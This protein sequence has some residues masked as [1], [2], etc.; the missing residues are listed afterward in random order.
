MAPPIRPARPIV[1]LVLGFLILAAGVVLARQWLPEWRGRLPEEAFFAQRYGE[2]ARQ[3]GVRLAPGAPRISLSTKDSLG[4]EARKEFDSL[5]PDVQT[6]LGAGLRVQVEQE[7][8]GVA[9][10]PP[11]LTLQ[12]SPQGLAKTVEWAPRGSEL[13]KRAAQGPPASEEPAK[14]F[15]RLLLAPGETLGAKQNADFPRNQEGRYL[16]QG[17]RPAQ[18]LAV[19]IPSADILIASRR[20]GDLKEDGDKASTAVEILKALPVILGFLAVPIL[21]LV[22][23]SKRRIDF[24]NGSVLAGLTFVASALSVAA[25]PSVL[26]AVGTLVPAFFLALWVFLVWSAGE[27]Y[28]RSVRTGFTTS[29]DALRS[30]RL[31]PRGGR[32][33]LY[34]LGLGAAAGGLRLA[35]PAIASALPGVWPKELSVSLPVFAT[36]NPFG[37]GAALA[38][39]VAVTVAFALRFLP[40]RWAPWAAAVAGAIVLTPIDIEP[41]AAGF[42]ASLALTGLLVFTLHRFGLTALLVASITCFL[43]PVSALTSTLIGWMPMTFTVTAGVPVLLLALGLVGLRRPEVVDRESLRQPAFIRR[44]EEERRI[45]YE[46]DLL[47]RMQLGLL[48]TELPHIDGW[49]IAARS[50]L[51]TEAGGDLYDFLRDENDD[52]WIAAGDVAGHGYSC[53]IAQAMTAAA[54][55]SLITAG[56]SPSSVLMGVD[57][58]IRR[59]GAH[60]HFTSL[61]L[62][63]LD[64]KT[65]EAL[66]SNAGHPFPLLLAHDGDVEEIDLPG[67]PLGQ[68]PRRQ[69]ADLR[70]TIP[71]G[72]ALVFCSDGLFEGT[73]AQD[74][75]YGYDRPRELLRRIGDRPALE[76]LETLFA[77]WRSHIHS[78]AA[79]SDDTTVVVIRKLPA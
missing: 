77:D 34:G 13:F 47:A 3:A 66:L 20:I 60:R 28:L 29:L 36:T 7:S 10:S 31:G 55:T 72:G 78:E 53:A 40:S 68:G 4:K 33:L 54:L 45:K 26:V 64:V 73:D 74:T 25:N 6:R 9:G 70:F 51:A 1:A 65:G 15:L 11:Q 41:Y 22:L 30:G 76:I 67:L 48:P 35:A 42:A 63:R 32:S 43:L 39:A 46:L 62:V 59:G 37:L 58:V 27:S 49:E 19:Q 24:V 21:F 17:S 44:L 2:L 52:L 57:R 14:R 12:F 69:Y 56:Q 23:L 75:A 79:P 8:A 50:L 38:G 5:S 71:A 61:A 16:I 18:H